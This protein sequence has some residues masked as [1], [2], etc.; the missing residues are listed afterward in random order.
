MLAAKTVYECRELAA[1]LFN[2]PS[3]SRVIFTS[4][5][6]HGLN[7]AIKTLAARRAGCALV[8]GY[9]HNSVMRP[10]RAAGVRTV[11]ARSEPFEPESAVFAFECA[12][13]RED[14]AFAVLNHMSN[15]F[16]YIL[17][18]ERIAE[19]CRERGVPL[20]LDASQSAGAA[21][22]DMGS[23]GA[24]FIAMPGH[25]GLYG[26]QGTGILLCRGAADGIIQGGT[27]SDSASDSMPGFPPDSLEAGTHNMPGIAGLREGIKF[28]LSRGEGRI[29]EHG[30][31]LMAMAERELA[32][33][34]G[35]RVFG[36]RDFC[37]G[38]ALSFFIDK[39][40]CE[41]AASELSLRGFA[42][43]AG[44]HCA[45]EAHRTAGTFETGTVRI[46]VSAFN[47]K[48]EL[49]GFADAVAEIARL[50]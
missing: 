44:L 43:R 28:V 31:G 41:E 26:P 14:A 7:I 6:T 45:P 27:G 10:L 12:L 46:S 36:G 48:R 37:R 22:V 32:V 16:G 49:C 24:E 40:G 5:A 13:E 11:I 2:A 17:P 38:G 29:L 47:T 20:I 30:R 35:V 3:P 18:A 50:A 25:K 19:R 34:P 33:I 21:T 8:S 42:V 1:R 9:E 23:L 15:V 4:N 39:M